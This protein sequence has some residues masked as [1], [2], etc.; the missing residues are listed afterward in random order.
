M[1]NFNYWG[2]TLILDI[3]GAS[4]KRIKDE[5]FIQDWTR[6][7][8]AIFEDSTMMPPSLFLMDEDIP[9]SSGLLVSQV[10][11]SGIMT[12][13][14]CNKTGDAYLDVSSNAYIDKDE[15]ERNFKEWFNPKSVRATL[16]ARLAA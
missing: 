1:S 5:Q 8:L 13:R 11:N 9:E 7:F 14:F 10:F 4:K 6:D 16:L 15:I 12:V 2:Y 3:K